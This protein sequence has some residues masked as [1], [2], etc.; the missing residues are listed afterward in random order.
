LGGSIEKK[1]F[2]A[3]EAYHPKYKAYVHAA[4]LS[5]EKTANDIMKILK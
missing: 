1:V 3:G 4:Y 2:F 5:G